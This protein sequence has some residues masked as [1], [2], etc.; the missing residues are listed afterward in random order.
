VRV[1]L[2]TWREG[3]SVHLGPRPAALQESVERAGIEFPLE[4]PATRPVR[5][6]FATAAAPEG[7]PAG[8]RAAAVSRVRVAPFDAGGGEPGT[9]VVERRTGAP[10]WEEGEADLSRFAGRRVLLRLESSAAPGSA[11]L[12]V[13][14]AEPTLLTGAPEAP[15]PWPPAAGA[16]SR[17]LGAAGPPAAQY[18]VRL[19]PGR[20]GLLDTAVGFIRDG[21]QLLFRGFRIRVLG[22]ALEDWRCAARLLE[23]REEPSPGGYRIRHRFQSWAGDFDLVG[24]LRVAGG[25]LQSKFWLENEPPP[26]P[27]LPVYIEDVA[28]GPWTERAARVY[29]GHGNVIEDPGAFEMNSNGHAL[30]ASFTGF[31]FA[32]GTAVVQAVDVPPEALRV[33][34]ETLSYSLHSPHRQTVTFI[35]APTVWEGAKTW[36]KLNG[37]TAPAGVPKL[38]GRFVIDLWRGGGDRLADDLA[39]AFRYGLTD[40][41]VILHSWQRP[42]NP[43]FGPAEKALLAASRTTTTS[44]TTPTRSSPGTRSSAFPPRHSTSRRRRASPTRRSSSRAAAN[45]CG[46]GSW[47]GS[48]PSHT[49]PGRIRSCRGSRRSGAS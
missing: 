36:R 3:F 21:K 32:G 16:A 4:L 15:Q 2:G 10:V 5:L 35:P 48:T 26:R 30:A 29:A 12:D 28:A 46:P 43:E 6:R 18:E 19:W 11:G 39:R 37:V 40:S 34:P 9:V 24:E 13:Y 14:W 42:P 44:T 8:P 17:P 45:R 38:A 47:K 7:T 25:A 20:R 31:D 41:M 22:D 23:V 27:W 33:E 1:K 49:G